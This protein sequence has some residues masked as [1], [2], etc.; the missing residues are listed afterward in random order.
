VPESLQE[1]QRTWIEHH[2]GNGWT[3][4]LWTDDNTENM[5]LYNRCF[6]DATEN[7]ASKSDLL[8]YEILYNYGGI[9][10]DMDFECLAPL[11]DLLC[12]DFFAGLEPLSHGPVQAGNALI[13]SRPGH[14]ILKH[15]METVKDDWLLYG[16]VNQTGPTH[17][18]RSFYAAGNQDGNRDIAFPSF[19]FYPID[20]YEIRNT[21]RGWSQPG[22]FGIHWWAGSWMPITYRA[23]MFKDVNK[24]LYWDVVWPDKD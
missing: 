22:V 8:R 5:Q 17:F 4:I 20:C 9:Y 7:H 12:Y 21:M 3:Y 13:A 15:C 18:T 1:L 14:P 19:Y 10:V 2:T 23:P 11:D 6:Y 16:I 24:D